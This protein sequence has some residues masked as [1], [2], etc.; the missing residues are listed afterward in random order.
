MQQISKPPSSQPG[1]L[2]YALVLVL[3]ILVAILSIF[4]LGDNIQNLRPPISSP[5]APASPSLVSQ[6]GL[7]SVINPLTV[8]SFV[9]LKGQ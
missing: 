1:L 8:S 5:T 2:E 4:F 3:I 6:S 7:A 9:S